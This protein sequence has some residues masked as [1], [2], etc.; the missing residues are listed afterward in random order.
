MSSVMLVLEWPRRR[1]SVATFCFWRSSGLAALITGRPNC[2]RW[3]SA[4]VSLARVRKVR[5]LACNRP[6]SA[7]SSLTD[8]RNR[9][10]KPLPI[11]IVMANLRWVVITATGPGWPELRCAIIAVIAQLLA[12]Q[13]PPLET[14]P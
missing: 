13:I 11:V 12:A 9:L 7:T 3:I 14:R 8:P 6:M 4:S 2:L 1:D 10:D 5:I